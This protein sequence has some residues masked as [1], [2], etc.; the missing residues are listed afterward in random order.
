[1]RP[2]G[3]MPSMEAWEKIRARGYRQFLINHEDGSQ[4]LITVGFTS[5]LVELARR[6][7]RWSSWSAPTYFQ[8]IWD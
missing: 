6:P 7:D 5:P 3:E 1:M 2:D 8:E 4:Q